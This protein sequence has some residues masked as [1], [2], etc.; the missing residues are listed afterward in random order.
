MFVGS[1]IFSGLP[2]S[3]GISFWKT[4]ISKIFW[5]VFLAKGHPRERT[6]K[7]KEISR[8]S[9]DKMVCVLQTLCLHSSLLNEIESVKFKNLWNFGLGLW[10]L[11]PR[12]I[13]VKCLKYHISGKNP[14]TLLLVRSL[15]LWH[16]LLS[17][18]KQ[19]HKTK[20]PKI[21]GFDFSNRDHQENWS[22]RKNLKNEKSQEFIVIESFAT[23]YHSTYT[24]V[25]QI[26]W[27]S[28]I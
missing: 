18:D 13:L 4:K 23:H 1:L 15:I 28:Q 6:W 26:R 22:K 25:Y 2:L 21:F 27:N 14:Q 24:Y 17:S 12:E 11:I 9:S 7:T 3:L 19:F 10:G 20:I 16:L 5:V 8:T